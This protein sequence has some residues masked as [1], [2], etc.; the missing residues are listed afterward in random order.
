MKSFF[1]SYSIRGI[2]FQNYMSQA[3]LD[4]VRYYGKVISFK[5]V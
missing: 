3:E 4:E 1:V 5:K 2:V